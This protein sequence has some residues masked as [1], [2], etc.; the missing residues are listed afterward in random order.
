VCCLPRCVRCEQSSERLA[1]A[2][3]WA[4]LCDPPIAPEMLLRAARVAV[5]YIGVVTRVTLQ[6]APLVLVQ[7]QQ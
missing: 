2:A 4:K 6:L 3:A 1:A 5:G 7:V